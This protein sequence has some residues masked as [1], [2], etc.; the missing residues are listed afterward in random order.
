MDNGSPLVGKTIVITR[1]QR[2][3]ADISKR[4]VA[5]GA[6]VVAFPLIA[7]EA[8][9]DKKLQQVQLSKLANYDYLIFTSR[10]AVEMTFVVLASLELQRDDALKLPETVQIAA[11]GKQTAKALET[12]GVSVSI[13]PTEMFNS[14]ALLEHFA[15]QNITSKRIAILRGEGGRDLL[16]ST[17]VERG[18]EVDY[19]DVYRRVCPVTNLLPLV[20]CQA[21]MGIDIITLTS[22][23]GLENLFKLGADQD[24]LKHTTLLVGSQRMADAAE[25]LDH[26]GRVIIA[27]D[28]SDDQMINCLLNWAS[29]AD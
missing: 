6:S 28:P 14:E 4:L 21:Q 23:E 17:L 9:R 26:Q 13:V 19:I 29:S 3:S 7:I 5:M 24:W 1:P 25:V 20:K 12:Q 16:R 22:V 11:V 8:S 18:A 10:N 15:L 27:D 2:Q